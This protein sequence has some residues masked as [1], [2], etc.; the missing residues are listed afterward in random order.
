MKALTHVDLVQLADKTRDAT[1][2]WRAC[3]ESDQFAGTVLRHEREP[4]AIGHGERFAPLALAQLVR[5]PA[6]AAAVR[7]VE[8]FD[9]Q[10]G[11]SGHVLVERF[12]NAELSHRPPSLRA[13]L[14]HA[15][16]SA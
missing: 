3:D 1:V 16:T 9:V 4:A 5:R 8:G 14:A 15:T 2:V 7:F 11:K 12:A 10:P 13:H 6:S